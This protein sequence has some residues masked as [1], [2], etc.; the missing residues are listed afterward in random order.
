MARLRMC[1]PHITYRPSS[2][3]LGLAKYVLSAILY[4]KEFDSLRTSEGYNS[5]LVA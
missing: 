3:L 4:M 5:K 1:P 2:E